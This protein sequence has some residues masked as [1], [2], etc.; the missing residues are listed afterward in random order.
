MSKVAEYQEKLDRY[1]LPDGITEFDL[2]KHEWV[3]DV[4]RYHKDYVD[5]VIGPAHVIVDKHPSGIRMY[6]TYHE[7]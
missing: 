5:K 3:R 4:S 2:G 7:N 6:V 1:S